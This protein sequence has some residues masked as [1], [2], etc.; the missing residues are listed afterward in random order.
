VV[1]IAIVIIAIGVVGSSLFD[2]EREA[3]LLP[4]E[5]IAI[6]NYTLVYNDLIP[7]STMDKMIISADITAYKGDKLIGGLKPQ[8]IFH[9]S[10]E[11]PV[12]EVAIHSTLAEDLY[13]ILAGWETITTEDGDIVQASFVVLVNPL[14]KWIWIGGGVFLLGGL[15]AFWP[16]RRE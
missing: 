5:S 13:V 4:G 1:H 14:V 7:E 2:V 9:R 6:N 11:Q 3:E 15:I 10:F 8:V 12:T 16:R